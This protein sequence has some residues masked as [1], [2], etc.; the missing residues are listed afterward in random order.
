M[1][2]HYKSGDH[3]ALAEIFSKAVQE[4][5]SYDYTQEQCDAWASLDINY[6]HWERRCELKRPF[7][8][9]NANGDIEGFLELDP[10]GHIDCAYVNPNYQRRGVVTRLCKHAIQTCFNFGIDRIYV[11]ASICAMPLFQKL[12]FVVMTEKLVRIG[13]EELKNYEMQLIPSKCEG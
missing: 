4:I 12:G 11:E 10:D 7:I 6:A 8:S 9:Q 5:A 3:I 13:E 2:R 1:I